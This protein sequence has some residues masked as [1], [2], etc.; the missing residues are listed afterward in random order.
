MQKL[1]SPDSY[2]FKD[3][4][5]QNGVAVFLVLL[6]AALS[7][8]WPDL[9]NGG[10]YF[11]DRFLGSVT[12]SDFLMQTSIDGGHPWFGWWLKLISFPLTEYKIYL[13]RA[14]T[15]LAYLGAGFFLWKICSRLR[16]LASWMPLLLGV[17][18]VT[19][20]VAPSIRIFIS[21]NQY[22]V[23]LFFFL[24]AFYTA[25]FKRGIVYRIFSLV[26]FAIS[27]LT[28]SFLVFYAIALLVM[29]IQDA[30]QAR[31]KLLATRQLFS[32][33]IDY[34]ILPFIIFFGQRY[35]F[36]SGDYNALLPAFALNTVKQ[37]PFFWH[38]NFGETFKAF[39]LILKGNWSNI[40]LMI[41]FAFAWYLYFKKKI[42]E[43]ASRILSFERMGICLMLAFLLFVAAIFPYYAVAKFP[44]LYDWHSRNQ[45]LVPF[46]W[47]F[48]SLAIV[49]FGMAVFGN[50]SA[51]VISGIL[52][53]SF[54]LVS[55]N[56]SLQY[57]RDWLKQLSLE[58]HIQTDKVFSD[59]NSF[60][61]CDDFRHNAMFRQYSWYDYQSLFYEAI[62]KNVFGEDYNTATGYSHQA[63]FVPT[64]ELFHKQKTTIKNLTDFARLVVLG[65]P[66]SVFP[67]WF[68]QKGDLVFVNVVVNSHYLASPTLIVDMRQALK[69]S[70]QRLL[71]P[72]RQ[73]QFL[74]DYMDI[75]TASYS[76]SQFNDYLME[77]IDKGSSA[78][79]NLQGVCGG[80]SD[81]RHSLMN[82]FQ[83]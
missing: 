26:C 25:I 72:A 19:V 46:S 64:M 57:Q 11:D 21:I 5:Q 68:Q 17:L 80:Q 30:E 24:M 73:N 69:F 4:T 29:L 6:I 62:G 3:Y 2:F 34:I 76:Q 31:F 59:S 75:K 22:V 74:L 67:E 37:L 13:S 33:R 14:L 39:K 41:V 1:A 55:L 77:Y 32:K 79:I 49:T 63:T 8:H 12:T 44:V 51:A 7:C 56:F 20:P 81:Y 36:P 40:G 35:F 60:I 50:W 71:N 78:K 23:C 38:A 65:P 48:L 45:L 9:L 15:F 47:V 42:K 54:T 70:L 66:Y 52:I 61:F 16:F 27:F 53:S 18:F 83:F 58:K 10:V 28:N 82:N 43:N